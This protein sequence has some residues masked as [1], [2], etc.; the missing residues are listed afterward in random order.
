MFIF[1][2]SNNDIV[3]FYVSG[4]DVHYIL[5]LYDDGYIKESSIIAHHLQ[6]TLSVS[7]KNTNKYSF[8]EG[9]RYYLHLVKCDDFM[10]IAIYLKDYEYISKIYK[11][12]IKDVR[13]DI[14]L[15]FFTSKYNKYRIEYKKSNI[16]NKNALEKSHKNRKD[17]QNSKNKSEIK[18]DLVKTTIQIDIRQDDARVIAE[19]KELL[20]EEK[21]YKMYK[22]LKELEELEEIEYTYQYNFENEESDEEN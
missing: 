18:D 8:K 12:K 7:F 3:W 4:N 13:E 17:N 2:K 5:N 6:E 21:K 14:W 11:Y 19:L 1:E 20:L 10:N 15:H 9:D 16:V 22:V